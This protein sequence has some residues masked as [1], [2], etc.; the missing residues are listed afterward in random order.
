[1]YQMT[2]KI[3]RINSDGERSKSYKSIHRVTTIQDE[4]NEMISITTLYHPNEKI[5]ISKED[6]EIEVFI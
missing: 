1:M 4:D 2:V 5:Y 6:H 3:F